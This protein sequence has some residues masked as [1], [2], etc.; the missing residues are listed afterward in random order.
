MQTLLLFSHTTSEGQHCKGQFH[1]D[2]PS[3]TPQRE[4]CLGSSSVI[5]SNFLNLFCQPQTHKDIPPAL[6]SSVSGLVPQLWCE[7][8]PPQAQG[9]C[10][11]RVTLAQLH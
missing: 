5:P 3:T 7:S 8:H 1:L 6:F 11:H 10:P 9:V 2:S 4:Q